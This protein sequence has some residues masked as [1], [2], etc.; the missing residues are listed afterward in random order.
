MEALGFVTSILPQ[1]LQLG[2]DGIPMIDKA[3][4]DFK[5]IGK[6][7]QATIDACIDLIS[8]QSEE[9]QHG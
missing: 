9:I 7:S 1:L 5:S 2:I 8:K 4:A 6:A 3:V